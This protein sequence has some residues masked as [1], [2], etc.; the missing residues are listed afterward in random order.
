MAER[1]FSFLLIFL[2]L[3]QISGFILGN[4]SMYNLGSVITASPF[5]KIFDK[6]DGLEYWS[7]KYSLK[8]NYKN[9]NSINLP[10]TSDTFSKIEGNHLIKI[11]YALSFSLYP[12]RRK[13]NKRILLLGICDGGPLARNFSLKEGIVSFD[14]TV[15]SKE[16]TK[17][18]E[19]RIWCDNG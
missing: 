11:T 2:G 5:P 15:F 14:L 7:Q 8:L 10:I 19:D 3:L 9:G 12:T 13:K 6:I 1:I 16:N 18:L 17:I 4:K